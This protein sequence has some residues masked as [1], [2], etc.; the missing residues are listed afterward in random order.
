MGTNSDVTRSRSRWRLGS[1]ASCWA[2]SDPRYDQVPGG[3]T[4]V[5]STAGQR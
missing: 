1:P 4:T 2:R 5:S 3:S